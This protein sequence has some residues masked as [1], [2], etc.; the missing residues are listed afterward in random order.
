M[1]LK[2]ACEISAE[3]GINVSPQNYTD[4]GIPMIRT[5]D[6]GDTG[7]LD[8][9]SAK[10]VPSNMTEG[11]LLKRGDLLLSRSGTIGRCLLYA[12]DEPAT[13]AAYLVRFRTRRCIVSPEF[14]AYWTQSSHF[15][16]QV[17]ANTITS[18]IDNFNGR[19]FGDLTLP[20]LPIAAQAEV[21]RFLSARL[22]PIDNSISL[23]EDSIRKLNLLRQA[24]IT[25]A[26]CDQ[27]PSIEWIRLKFV[28]DVVAG[29]SPPSDQ[30]NDEGI[31][32][33][34]LQGSAEFGDSTPAANK[35]CATASKVCRAGDWLMSVRAPVGTM[36][37]AD[38]SYGI[39]RGL[40]AIQANGVHA[41]YL[42]FALEAIRGDLVKQ[43][44]GTTY[45]AVS[46]SDINNLFVPVP[47]QERQDEIAGRLM[48]QTRSLDSL[49]R[50]VAG[51]IDLLKEYRS[52][53]ISVAVA[54]QIDVTDRASLRVAERT[55]EDL[56]IA[57]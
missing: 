33:P 56:E 6:Y 34:F 48:E 50:K 28:A 25:A 42:G 51:S 37:R 52:A 19:K 45:D 41:E 15:V 32:M 4:G 26:I 43:Y 36:N 55:L 46:T 13:F 3:Y 49:V 16:K 1:K 10:C 38:Q 8:L 5:S 17:K 35:F 14:V 21:V 23:K 9:T 47:S 12:S 31:G 24:A 20:L 53:L 22:G 7:A 29:Q 11:K 54:G 27:N 44:K 18:T 30:V 39:G 57:R 2:Q 40:C